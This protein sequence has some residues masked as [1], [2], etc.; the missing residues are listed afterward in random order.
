MPVRK[1]SGFSEQKNPQTG[2]FSEMLYPKYY[3]I[4]AEK[5]ETSL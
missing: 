2:A 1:V 3:E 5:I 4:K